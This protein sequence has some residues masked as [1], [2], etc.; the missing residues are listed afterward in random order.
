[1]NSRLGANSGVSEVVGEMLMVALVVLLVSAFVAVLPQFLPTK[2]DP[3]ITILMRNDT[4]GNITLWHKGGDWIKAEDITIIVAN[5]TKRIRFS[6]QDFSLVP[7][8]T[9]FDLGSNIMVH[10]TYPLEGNETVSLVTP[11]AR[12]F[13]GT[14]GS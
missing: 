2:N 14:M 9:V 8:K 5:S 10:V 11:N 1:M 4:Q 12:I 6:R 7:N 13:S 3:S